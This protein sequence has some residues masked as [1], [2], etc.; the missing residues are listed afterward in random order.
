M[1]TLNTKEAINWLSHSL[2]M[3]SDKANATIKLLQCGEKIKEELIQFLEKENPYPEDVFLP[4]PK[5]DF[6]KI[7]NWLKKEL[8][9]SIDRLSGNMGRKIYKSIIEEIKDV[10]K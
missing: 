7:N 8:G 3:N 4:I 6:N 2:V 1:R 9:Y 10:V 5:E